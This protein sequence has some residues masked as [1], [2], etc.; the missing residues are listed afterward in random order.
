MT[1]PDLWSVVLE[2]TGRHPDRVVLDF[3]GTRQTW[4]ELVDAAER[5]AAGLA[6]AGISRGDVVCHL[7]P[8]D[9]EVVVTMLALVRLGA[10]ECPV[11]AGL[12][13]A[14]LA[15]VLRH[16]GA[17]ALVV[18]GGLL[19]RLDGVLT[20]AP[21]VRMVVV[22]G[23]GA[24]PPGPRVIAYDQVLEG[25]PSPPPYAVPRPADP[26]CIVYTSG[27]TGPAKGAVLPHGFP[28][29]QARIKVEAW[30]LGPDDVLFTTLPLYHVNARF[31]TLGTALVSGSRAAVQPGF[32]AGSFWEAVRRTR[33]DRDR[34][35]RGDL[36][37]PAAP[38]GEPA[39]TAT[40][41]SA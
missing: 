10:V 4:Q 5:C 37:H 24:V 30:S 32:S 7:S 22:R 20:E 17:T 13:G 18:D 12:R 40:T 9:A 36:Q 39:A 38:A 16:S 2:H 15:H 3:D 14:Q 41:A 21:A 29:E 19:E 33:R 6:A 23:D 11:N 28:I 27:T 34:H 1:A 31:S 8:N 26:L 25:G 35:R